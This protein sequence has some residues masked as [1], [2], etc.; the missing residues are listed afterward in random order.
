MLL[1]NHE[2]LKFLNIQ[3]KLSWRYA[4][5]VGFLQTFSFS[6]KHKYRIH[7]IFANALSQRHLLLTNMQLEVIG[8][9][10]LKDVY[11]HDGGFGK[12]WVECESGVSKH[13][14]VLKGYLFKRNCLCF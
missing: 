13:F 10:I 9:K 2:D 7:N 3:Q 11:K 12:I 5:W 14:V 6:M 4:Y 8:F 1:F